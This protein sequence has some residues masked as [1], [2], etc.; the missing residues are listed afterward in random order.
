MS[1]GTI[2]VLVGGAI[3]GYVLWSRAE[4]DALRNAGLRY[5]RLGKR[6]EPYPAWVQD[7][8]GQSGVYVFRI[9]KPD[10]T[11]EIVYVG[12][13]HTGNLFETLTRHLQTWTR[14]KGFWR[15]QYTEGTDPGVTYKRD[16][17]EAAVRVVS[18]DEAIELEKRLIRR[19]SPRDNIVGNAEA[20]PF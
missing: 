1:K 6:F 17:V 7:L 14:Q 19:Y 13:S 18:P 9:I 5:R 2:A 4:K 15:G 10:G 20:V 16:Q 12:E 11:P 8:K 3:V